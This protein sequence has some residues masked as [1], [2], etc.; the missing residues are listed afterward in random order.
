M[1]QLTF[2]GLEF[3]QLGPKAYLVLG[4]WRLARVSGNV[5]GVFTLIF[6]HL[7]EGW[8][9]IHDHT[10]LVPAKTEKKR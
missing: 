5:G 9:I 2:S 10:S 6:L 1:G 7:P 3:R 4:Q 8:R